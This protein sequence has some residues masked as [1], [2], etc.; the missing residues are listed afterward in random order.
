MV[1]VKGST[2]RGQELIARGNHFEGTRLSQIYTRWSQA[3]QNA[4]DWCWSEYVATEQSTAFGI[5]SHNGWSFSV[6]WLGVKDG[7]NIMRLETSTNSY[8]IWLDR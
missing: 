4:F 5:C 1:E 3:K 8:L 7:E 6:S 2:K